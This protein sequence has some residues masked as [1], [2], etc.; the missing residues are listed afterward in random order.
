M[1]KETLHKAFLSPRTR[2]RSMGYA[3][4]GIGLFFRT[5]PHAWIHL[6]ATLF[7]AGLLLALPCSR[8]EII[9][10]SITAGLVWTAELFNTAIEKLCDRITTAPDTAVAAVK[11]ISAAAV[12]LI[13]ITALITG[14]LIFL[15]KLF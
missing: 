1:S 12:L 4:R 15:P 14:A 13:S 5:E 9:L 2:M 10:V 3:L 8:T 6:L 11:D 7:A